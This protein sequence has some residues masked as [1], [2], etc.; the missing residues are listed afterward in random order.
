MIHRRSIP[1]PRADHDRSMRFI[2]Y[3]MAI[4][5]IVVAG[6]LAFVR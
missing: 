6:I 1:A 5:A 2:E 4:V 3:G